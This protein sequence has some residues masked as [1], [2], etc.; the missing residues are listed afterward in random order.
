MKRE[1]IADKVKTLVF[2]IMD[3]PQGP[4]TEDNDFIE[5]LDMDSL[6]LVELV[7]AIERDFE[8]TITDDDADN[9]KKVGDA[10]DVVDRKLRVAA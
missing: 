4:V 7:M 3:N 2:D 10:I 6:H 1:E 8:I 5:D 9:L